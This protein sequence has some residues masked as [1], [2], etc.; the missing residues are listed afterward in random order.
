LHFK[1]RTLSNSFIQLHAA[2][3]PE[4]NPQI[5]IM[6]NYPT[7]P[8]NKTLM[9]FAILSQACKLENVMPM[10]KVSVAL[11]KDVLKGVISTSSVGL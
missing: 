7:S 3:E 10:E 1:I 9:L 5:M 2:R 6:F 11:A 8:N 4:T